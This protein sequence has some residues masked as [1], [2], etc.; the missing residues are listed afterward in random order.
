[1]PAFSHAFALPMPPAQ[2][3]SLFTPRGEEGWVPGWVPRYIDPPDGETRQGM[4]FATHA[5]SVWWTCLEWNPAAGAVRYVRLTPGIKVARVSV[6]CQSAGQ[7][8]AAGTRVEVG[9]EWFALGPAG[10]AELAS[11]TPAAFADEIEG[12]RD[13]ILTA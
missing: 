3:L 13:L 6:S 11:L 8:A 1:M 10:E 7:S 5:D 12:W 4:L 2:A 9:Y